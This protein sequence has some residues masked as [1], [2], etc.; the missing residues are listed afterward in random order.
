MKVLLPLVLFL[1][2]STA[3]AEENL[4]ERQYWRK[5]QKDI[6]EEIA[7]GE[8]HCGVTFEFEWIDKPALRAGITKP[9]SPNERH[10]PG[11]VCAIPMSEAI[12]LCREGGKAKEAVV[13]KF[14]GFRCG[15]AKNRTLKLAKSVVTF[16]GNYDQE[17]L[18]QWMRDQLLSKL[19][20]SANVPG[21]K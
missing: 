18:E 5:Q 9:K 4:E 7:Y 16:M 19:P 12:R 15:Y 20:K 2:A 17:R 8:E 21:P 6:D 14:K 10:R 3:Y 1:S 13:A 11:Y